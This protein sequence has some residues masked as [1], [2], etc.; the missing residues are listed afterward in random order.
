LLDQLSSALTDPTKTTN[1]K[2]YWICI[3]DGCSH[4]REGR[5]TTT[6]ILTHALQCDFLRQQDLVAR[7]E[8]EDMHAKAALGAEQKDADKQELD[9]LLTSRMRVLCIVQSRTANL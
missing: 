7:K 3:A 2:S 8:A 1:N 5:R 6:E 4:R 9:R